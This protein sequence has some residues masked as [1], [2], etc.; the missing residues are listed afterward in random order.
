MARRRNKNKQRPGKGTATDTAT[1]RGMVA[2]SSTETATDE[3]TDDSSD[4]APAGAIA[5]PS[6]EAVVAAA[7]QLTGDPALVVETPLAGE[8]FDALELD[9]FKRAE[10]LYATSFETWEDLDPE[11]KN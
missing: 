10:E 2:A 1:E 11:A 9:F 4:A 5:A 6:A 8:V 7:T 3:A